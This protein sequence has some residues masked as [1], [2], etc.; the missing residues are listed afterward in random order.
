MTTLP[1]PGEGKGLTQLRCL[2]L[3]AL[4]LRRETLVSANAKHE[5]QAGIMPPARL[6]LGQIVPGTRRTRRQVL[7][8]DREWAAYHEAGHF[9]AARHFSAFSV[10]SRIWETQEG[11]SCED[12]GVVGTT[13]FFAMRG[14]SDF[15]FAVVAWAGCLAEELVDRIFEEWKDDLWWFWEASGELD[16]SPK[17]SCS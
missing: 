9:V 14:A 11:P 8:M 3:S 15:R 5:S 2:F 10:E 1:N 13:E 12:N 7:D 6:D 16:I 4:Q 17:P